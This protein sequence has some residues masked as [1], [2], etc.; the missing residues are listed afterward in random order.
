MAEAVG[1]R[2]PNPPRSPGAPTRIVPGG[3]VRPRGKRPASERNRPDGRQAQGPAA[4]RA[5]RVASRAPALDRPERQRSDRPAMTKPAIR[6]TQPGAARRGTGPRA[7][8]IGRSTPA[9]T[10]I[11]ASTGRNTRLGVGACTRRPPVGRATK[12]GSRTPARRTSRELRRRPPRRGATRKLE[13]QPGPPS[14]PLPR[15]VTPPLAIATGA[16]GEVKPG[17][18]IGGRSIQRPQPAA[19]GRM[20]GTRKRRGRAPRPGQPGPQPGPRPEPNEMRGGGRPPARWN[21]PPPVFAT[22]RRPPRAVRQVPATRSAVSASPSSRGRRWP[23]RSRASS[24]R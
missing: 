7:A 20:R 13:P 17:R 5:A 2:Q 9:N 16:V 10:P 12:S 8:S 22:L 23:S 21:Q 1:R 4:R 24:G 6:S 11:P 3:R 14:P 19:G 15:P 18:G